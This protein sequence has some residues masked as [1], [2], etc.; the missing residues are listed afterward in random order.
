[1]LKNIF[2]DT[3]LSEFM[4][5][6]KEMDKCSL[7][8][9]RIKQK[10]KSLTIEIDQ[11]KRKCMDEVK[12]RMQPI[13]Q[14][15]PQISLSKSHIND[16][17]KYLKGTFLSKKQEIMTKKKEKNIEFKKL[18]Q[19]NQTEI[20]M[21]HQLEHVLQDHKIYEQ[22]C[23]YIND[24]FRLWGGHQEDTFCIVCKEYFQVPYKI[25]TVCQCVYNICE[26]CVKHHYRTCSEHN[27][28]TT[29]KCILCSEQILSTL[30]TS[31][32]F[33]KND[34]LFNNI[35]NVL[36]TIN[37]EIKKNANIDIKLVHCLRCKKK[38]KDLKD[39]LKH[40]CI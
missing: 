36:T 40:D 13:L 35:N 5:L 16:Y 23:V 28:D 9:N 24:M 22:I 39:I 14:I 18:R 7:E 32:Y 29:I 8:H 10:V 20:K 12:H 1:M 17:M 33:S 37:K 26:T 25:N 6:K 27:N 30:P 15:E 34:K 21:K 2:S 11:M 38:F 19:L 4:T 3:F 31:Q